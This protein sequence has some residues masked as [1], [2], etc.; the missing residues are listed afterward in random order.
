MTSV[1]IAYP[2]GEPKPE[3]LRLVLDGKVHLRIGDDWIDEQRLKN[4]GRFSALVVSTK[5]VDA[6]GPEAF[7]EDLFIKEPCPACGGPMR[8]GYY[9]A[10]GNCM[11]CQTTG[12]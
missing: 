2:T 6:H 10:W 1:D 8:V 9:V 11:T 5:D 4:A 3:D 12:G 7:S